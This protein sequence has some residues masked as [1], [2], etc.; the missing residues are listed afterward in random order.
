[1]IMPPMQGEDPKPPYG[2]SPRARGTLDDA[3]V[4]AT[5]TLIE[6]LNFLL[7]FARRVARHRDVHTAKQIDECR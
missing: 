3:R 7:Q 4:S 6:S 1:M 5:T 2:S